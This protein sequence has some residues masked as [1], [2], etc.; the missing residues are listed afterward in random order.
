L[1]QRAEAFDQRVDEAFPL[2]TEQET[3]LFEYLN[4][5]YILVAA[6]AAKRNFLLIN[7]NWNTGLPKQKNYSTLRKR[8]VQRKS[9]DCSPD[10]PCF[11]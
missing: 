6:I 8:F 5:A 4:F 3:E 1:R 2:N 7:L 11:A 10:F 9:E